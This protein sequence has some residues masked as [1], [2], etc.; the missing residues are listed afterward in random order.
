MASE[1]STPRYQLRERAVPAIL[2]TPVTASN[3][4]VQ[5]PVTPAKNFFDLPPELRCQV[6][7]QIFVTKPPFQL[8]L[9]RSSDRRR[10]DRGMSK[11][12]VQYALAD[13]ISNPIGALS[14]RPK[15]PIWFLACKQMC[16]EAIG[17]FQRG[18]TW[19]L[20]NIDS[21]TIPEGPQFSVWKNAASGRTRRVGPFLLT[22]SD[23]QDIR[24]I[25]GPLMHAFGEIDHRGKP[26]NRV[27][28]GWDNDVMQRL[29]SSVAT[30]PNLRSL[31]VNIITMSPNRWNSKGGPGNAPCKVDY[32][33]LGNLE[34]PQLQDLKIELLYDTAFATDGRI[35]AAFDEATIEVGMKLIGGKGTWSFTRTGGSWV[36]P[37]T[38][39]PI[40]LRVPYNFKRCEN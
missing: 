20:S 37:R 3:L 21:F 15:P 5:G 39:R 32:K 27:T 4:V 28:W 13:P 31:T 9:P 30:S 36:A 18:A 29:S 34:L 11:F 33:W 35:M 14:T 6:Y 22:P 26:F 38:Q 7:H 2:P 10:C 25:S 17:Q 8:K 24:L 40:C 12:N 16:I 19:I 1:S 23:A